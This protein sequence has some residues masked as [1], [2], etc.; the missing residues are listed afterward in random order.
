MVALAV[1][2]S[3]PGAAPW[4]EQ[5]RSLEDAALPGLCCGGLWAS[6]NVLSVYTTLRLGQAVG[7]PLTQVC[8]G[9]LLVPRATCKSRQSCPSRYRCACPPAIVVGRRQMCVYLFAVVSALW[10]ILYFGE[11]RDRTALMVFT[12]ASA[13]VLSSA[14]ALKLAGD[15]M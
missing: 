5:R 4:A 15:P 14:T 10:G 8:V 13:M 3:G 9:A 11:L 6:G 1:R 2:G 12:A 7:F